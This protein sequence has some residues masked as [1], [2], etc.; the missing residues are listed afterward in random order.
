MSDN[1]GIAAGNPGLGQVLL[2]VVV[3]L[4]MIALLFG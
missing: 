3:V 2:A 1:E 4:I